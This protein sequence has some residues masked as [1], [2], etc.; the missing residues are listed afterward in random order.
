MQMY[1]R[2][3]FTSVLEIGRAGDLHLIIVRRD[4]VSHLLCT[5][6]VFPVRP[7]MV[8]H[9]VYMEIVLGAKWERAKREYPMHL[10]SFAMRNSNALVYS[11]S[12][13]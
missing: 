12:F 7:L 4:A 9:P 2:L 5:R 1:T 11:I 3:H 13:F 10:R 6:G 8:S